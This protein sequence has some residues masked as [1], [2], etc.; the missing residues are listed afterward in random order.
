MVLQHTQC[1]SALPNKFVIQMS[2]LTLGEGPQ[3][4]ESE[5]LVVTRRSGDR[6]SGQSDCLA[7]VGIKMTGQ[8]VPP[9]S[10]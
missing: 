3:P 4:S 2:T 6:G 5:K 10:A 9:P 8:L 1:V 7:T